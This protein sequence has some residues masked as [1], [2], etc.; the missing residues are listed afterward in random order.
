[1]AAVR[2]SGEIDISEE[3][4]SPLAIGSVETASGTA[5]EVLFSLPPHLLSLL[6][7]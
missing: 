5:A 4:F 2:T 1:M 7:V 6:E 3:L